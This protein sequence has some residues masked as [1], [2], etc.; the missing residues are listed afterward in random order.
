MSYDREA[1]TDRDRDRIWEQF[2]S[3]VM[4]WLR[5]SSIVDQPSPKFQRWMKGT[6]LLEITEVAV[7]MGRRWKEEELQNLIDW[8]KIDL[9]AY[10]EDEANTKRCL[11][12]RIACEKQFTPSRN[13]DTADLRKKIE[14]LEEETAKE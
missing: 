1:K 2:R 5:N 7:Q 6:L 11:N 4:K 9:S 12:E 13:T 8:H 14:A 3:D 10:V